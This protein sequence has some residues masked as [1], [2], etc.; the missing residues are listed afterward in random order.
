[1]FVVGMDIGYS[2]LK[3]VSGSVDGPPMNVSIFPV[4]AAPIE[5]MSGNVHGEIA[6]GLR[7]WV[8]GKPYIAGVEPERLANWERA[9]HEDY[10]S[11]SEYRALFHAALLQTGRASIDRLVTGLPV[12]HFQDDRV[13]ARLQSR[14]TGIHEV[15]PGHA[16]R[17]AEV[18]VVPQPVG[19]YL[20][21]A[22]SAGREEDI[23]DAEILVIDPGFFSVD[24]IY[25]SGT[26]IR[27]EWSGSSTLATSHLLEETSRYIHREYEYRLSPKK[28][29]RAVREGK[30]SL[31]VGSHKI[32]I[33]DAIRGAAEKVGPMVM[34]QLQASMRNKQNDIGMVILSGGGA[35]FYRRAVE[36]IFPRAE[37]LVPAEPVTAN[38]KGFW[39]YGAA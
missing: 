2:N 28:I 12:S 20:D 17:V 22:T 31:A 33:A 39:Y 16:V 10:P 5:Q 15:A 8:D 3:V 25:L 4:G 32:Q 11:S 21:A 27:H 35:E 19:S 9:L 14:L 1:M 23:C 38:A 24:W 18:T 30:T 34:N 29:E 6:G 26:D 7:V 36:E 13:K 37:I